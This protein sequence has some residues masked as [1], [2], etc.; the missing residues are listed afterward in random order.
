MKYFCIYYIL[1]FITDQNKFEIEFE[2]ILI[3]KKYS[4]NNF[5]NLKKIT[6]CDVKYII[7]FAE[8][9]TIIEIIRLFFHCPIHCKKKKLTIKKN[10]FFF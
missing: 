8:N 9:S 1:I 2:N 4:V 7:L 3:K 6:V 5:Y 10:V